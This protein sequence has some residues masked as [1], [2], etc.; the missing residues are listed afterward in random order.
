MMKNKATGF[1]KTWLE[2]D[3]KSASIR[4]NVIIPSIIYSILLI[5]GSFAHYYVLREILLGNKKVELRGILENK[6]IITNHHIK[7]EV[8]L[9]RRLAKTQ[10]IVSYCV[11]PYNHTNTKH[12][13]DEINS[14]LKDPTF[15]G[16]IFWAS[17]VNKEFY[18]DTGDHYT[19]DPEKDTE[20]WYNMT[21]KGSDQGNIN[22]NYNKRMDQMKLWI[23]MPVY[24]GN[25]KAVGLVG[26][27][28]DLD[29]LT[30]ELSKDFGKNAVF[31]MFNK[32]GEI[33]ITNDK[34]ESHFDLVSLKKKIY[35][36]LRDDGIIIKKLA[37]AASIAS[38]DEP[39]EDETE[40]VLA[41][42]LTRI[43]MHEEINWYCIVYERIGFTDIMDNPMTK[44]FLIFFVANFLIFAFIF[45]IVFNLINSLYKN[46]DSAKFASKAKSDFLAKM[47]HEIRT[48]MNAIMGMAELALSKELP[49]EARANVQ[50]IKQA[51]NNLLAIINDILDFSKIE[52]GKLEIIEGNY[53]FSSLINDVISIIRIRTVDS[54]IKFVVNID[55]N[56]PNELFGDE[57]KIRQVM[58][59][60][61]GN[62]V[63]YTENGH[64]AFS[65]IGE[66]TD[67]NTVVLTI[68]VEDTGK[69]IK[70]E[71]IGKIFDGFTQID[72]KRNKGIE[73]TGLG[74]S[75]ARNLI[76][77]MNGHIEVYSEYG[78]G[79]TFTVTLPQKFSDPTP[80]ASVADPSKKPVLVYE[81]RQIF[82]ESIVC[83]IDNLGASCTLVFSDSEFHDKMASGKFSFAF[84]ASI[85]YEKVKATCSKFARSVNII[86]LADFG[87]IIGDQNLSVVTMP[88]NSISIA[89][90]LNGDAKETY[91]SDTRESIAKFTAPG[92]KALIVD[93]VNTNLHVAKGLLAYYE[94]ASTLC[95]S[96]PAAIEA[97]KSKEFDFVFMDHMM[98]GMDGVEA[99][100]RIRAMGEG[101]IYYKR[102]PIIALTANAISGVKEMFLA[103]GFDDFLSKPIEMSQLAAVLERWVPKSKQ[104]RHAQ[105]QR[106]MAAPI[107]NSDA[108]RHNA[109]SDNPLGFEIDGIDI[110]AGLARAAGKKDVFIQILNI[111]QQEW[112]EKIHTLKTAFETNKINLFVTYVHA[113]K[114]AASNI[115][116]A[117]LSKIAA[118]L[119]NAGN[120]MDIEFVQGNFDDLLSVLD[121]TLAS[122]R[123]VLNKNSN[124]VGGS[125]DVLHLRT[126]LAD[127]KSALERQDLEAISSAAKKLRPFLQAPEIGSTI[128]NVL[129]HTLTG[130]YAEAIS[131]INFLLQEKK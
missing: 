39:F 110:K 70:A 24:D 102:L 109:P 119:E 101:D 129:H 26:T 16:S 63:K 22:I 121:T 111:F 66:Q 114:S 130:E 54:K 23:N 9:A 40:N 2:N 97:V 99:T 83:T 80:L 107:T 68:V 59:N 31:Y 74:L 113:L 98:P 76:D 44:L 37:T 77:A 41:Y 96:G 49:K 123:S 4:K 18:F 58:L 88:V 103:N 56:I 20:Y 100:A 48:P 38:I 126:E 81:T 47:S 64:V 128:E 36:V 112:S 131:T 51:G 91:Y 94:I 90:I 42:A 55:C 116:A 124:T 57:I 11:N 86:L 32:D 61:L 93:D 85:H 35:D 34:N 6:R 21:L 46:V 106:G 115:G 73:G 15:H 43:P 12:A 108:T 72:H 14:Y 122:I 45:C 27:G 1:E 10:S 82:S 118:S 33:T 75:I 30:L 87:E 69:G 104:E 3:D 25:N 28:V 5:F 117:K 13:L 92:A 78:V 67:E 79:S 71:D 52:T 105:E 7:T 17:D 120:K 50:T 62:A 95:T 84:V 53:L 19:V 60:I 29:D 8:A 89:N 125:V 65:V 127:L